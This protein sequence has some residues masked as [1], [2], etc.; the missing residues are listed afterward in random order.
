MFYTI[1]EKTNVKYSENDA[2]KH[3]VSIA[4]NSNKKQKSSFG[5]NASKDP[6]LTLPEL[7]KKI[8]KY[9]S[10]NFTYSGSW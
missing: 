7:N 1:Q 6:T 9:L 8:E 3:A 2:V 4:K 10:E 5:E